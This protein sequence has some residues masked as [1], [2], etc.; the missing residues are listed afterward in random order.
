[1]ANHLRTQQ[2]AYI[3]ATTLLALPN[4][5][6]N[7]YTNK[8]DPLDGSVEIPALLVMQG[9]DRVISRSEG[10]AVA[11]VHRQELHTS[12][13]MLVAKVKNAGDVNDLLDTLCMDVKKRLCADRFLGGLSDDVRHIADGQPQFDSSG[14]QT[15]GMVEMH[16]EIDY[17]CNEITPDVKN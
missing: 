14:D 4:V 3:A 2:R 6:A 10:S 9:D 8:T 17:W 5:G 13:L 12:A 7:I 15:V 16:Y 1:M 11:N